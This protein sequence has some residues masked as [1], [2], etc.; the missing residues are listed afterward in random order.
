MNHQI[1][2]ELKEKITEWLENELVGTAYIWEEQSNPMDDSTAQLMSSCMPPDTEYYSWV[3]THQVDIDD[4]TLF[5]QDEDEGI[6]VKVDANLYYSEGKKDDEDDIP[7]EKWESGTQTYYV[8][9]Q[10]ENMG[11]EAMD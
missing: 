9:I 3:E 11:I 2:T 7:E 10:G 4:A 1:D 8:R 6:L 5:E